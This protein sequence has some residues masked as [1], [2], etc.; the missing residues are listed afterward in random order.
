MKPMA[1]VQLPLL[2]NCRFRSFISLFQPTLLTSM[3]TLRSSFTVLLLLINFSSFQFQ[4]SSGHASQAGV[5]TIPPKITTPITN[6]TLST[7][8]SCPSNSTDTSNDIRDPCA[9][10]PLTPEL[11][12]SLNLD[13]YLSTFPGGK[14]LS[15]EVRD[16][17][18]TIVPLGSHLSSLGFCTPW[19]A[20]C[21]PIFSSFTLH[22]QL[23]AEKV[24]A[25]NFECGIGQ[26]CN[27]NQVSKTE[28]FFIAP[29]Y[30]IIWDIL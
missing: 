22:V 16:I 15:L 24:G 6:N 26:M 9:R 14:N 12:H 30:L 25:T 5:G 23:F 13:H 11:W 1:L 28:R 2:Y 10:L 3:H 18:F 19:C 29:E 20:T 17:S 4:P 8:T 21:I 27:A 7:N